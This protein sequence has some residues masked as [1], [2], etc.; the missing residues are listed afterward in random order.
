LYG[1]GSFIYKAGPSGLLFINGESVSTV[2]GKFPAKV[3]HR[4]SKK[5]THLAIGGIA[6]GTR[7]ILPPPM[8]SG[9]LPPNKAASIIDISYVGEHGK[10]TPFPLDTDDVESES[11]CYS[12]TPVSGGKCFYGGPGGCSLPPV[13]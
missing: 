7:T 11:S 6:K 3:F 5:A 8:G 10:L 12:I 13:S 2:V 4:L 9:S 1:D